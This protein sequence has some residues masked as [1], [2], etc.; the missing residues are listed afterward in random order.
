MTRPTQ[1]LS[2]DAIANRLP[3]IPGWEYG[4]GQLAKSFAFKDFTEAV[5][6][7]VRI[8]FISEK[9]DHHAEITNLYNRVTL[10]INTHTVKGI[11]EL[12]FA[13]AG[14]VERMAN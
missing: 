11:T 4:D 6:F 12:D 14:E 13:F 9:L 8:S 7:I 10:K 5:A 3:T 1:A 2:P